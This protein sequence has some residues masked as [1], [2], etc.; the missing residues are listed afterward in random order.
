MSFK[1]GAHGDVFGLDRKYAS[2]AMEERRSVILKCAR[3]LIRKGKG[4]FSMRELAVESGVALGTL[5]NNFDG[6]ADIVAQAILEVYVKR[7]YEPNLDI[8]ESPLEHLR[9]RQS[10]VAAEVLRRP[11]FARQMVRIYFGGDRKLGA[12][13]HAESLN[14]KTA[15]VAALRK[16]AVLAE[17]VE[18]HILSENLSVSQYGIIGRW[19]AG[20]IANKM[21]A[22]RLEFMTLMLLMA[23][24]RKSFQSKIQER[25]N[26]LN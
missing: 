15:L 21:L 9:V 24:T 4:D 7:I 8:D 20:G 6:Q 5:Y 2:K 26:Q 13:L 12:L 19:A 3:T 10:R 23:T 11:D 25:L 17:G 14:D 16:R 1:N 18:D 22:Y